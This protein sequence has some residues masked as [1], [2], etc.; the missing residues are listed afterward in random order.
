[1]AQANIP[2]EVKEVIKTNNQ[3]LNFISYLQDLING[4]SDQKKIDEFNEEI[5]TE[6]TEYIY[7]MFTSFESE[8]VM[9]VGHGYSKEDATQQFVIVKWLFSFLAREDIIESYLV[10]VFNSCNKELKTWFMSTYKVKKSDYDLVEKLSDENNDLIVRLSPHA[11][12][13]IVRELKY[14]VETIKKLVCIL[15]L[16]KL[17]RD[18]LLDYVDSDLA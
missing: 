15:L 11:L 3:R 8:H 5:G 13:D 14:T 17:H 1:M 4:K 6:C 18:A 7:E 10:E 16:D 12:V 2:N 9:K